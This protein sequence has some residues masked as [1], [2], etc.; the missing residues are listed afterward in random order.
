[1]SLGSYFNRI[2][3][4]VLSG[5]TVA[6][7]LVPEAVAF[8]LIAH[9]NPLVGLYAA[10]I[11]CFVTSVFGGRPAMISA[12]TGALAVVMGSLVLAHGVEY[13]FATVVLMGFLQLLA[14]VLKLGKFIRIVPYSVLLGFVNGIAIV[15]FLAQLRQFKTVGPAGEAV[16]LSG[17]ALWIM[18]GIVALTIGIMV[19]L[20]KVTKAVPAALAAI[21]VVFGLT[22]FLGIETKS[23]GD[24]ASISGGFPSFH[25]PM[26]PWTWETL[27]IILP[28]AIIFS[29]IGLIQSLLVLNLVDE[30]TETHGR[31]SRECLA[32]GAANVIS[33]F[34]ASMGGAALIGQSMINLRSGARQRLSGITASLCLLGFILFGAPVIEE[35]PLAALVGVMFMVVVGTFAWSSLR[36]LNKIPRSDAFIIILVSAITVFA[37][38][39]MAVFAGVILSALVYA[40]K[41]S[42][43]VTARTTTDSQRKEKVYNLYGPVFFGSIVGFRALFNPKTDPETVI[44]NF[45]NS[46]I[47][48]HSAIDALKKLADRYRLLGKK[49]VYRRLSQDCARLLA[50]TDVQIESDAESDPH[51]AVVMD[52]KHNPGSK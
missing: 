23:V 18:L 35:I 9:V 24:M 32:L 4:E 10:F 43:Y 50:P 20:P 46:R 39:A 7:A 6:I 13:L 38:L 49:I 12:A 25:L 37:D 52:R 41:S 31:N 34:C 40:W 16:W 33:G 42:F 15:I 48:D 44:V 11:L 29:S 28:Y 36:V 19:F 3:I 17:Q 30:V 1:M 21:L 45:E 5:L 26:V 8:S 2:K 51:Y 14:G 22:Y 27:K 47:W